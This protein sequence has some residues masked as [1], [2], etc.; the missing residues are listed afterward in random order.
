MQ[1][2][3][4]QDDQVFVTWGYAFPYVKIGA[5]DNDEFLRNFHAIA[6]DWFQRTPVTSAMMSRY[7]LKNIFKDLV[8]NPKAFLICTPY[9][10]NLYR[11]YMKEKFNENVRAKFHFHSDQFTVLSINSAKQD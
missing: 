6:L 7:G 5:F 1:S 2:L 3:K 11:I 4:P 9:Q 10:W 8:D